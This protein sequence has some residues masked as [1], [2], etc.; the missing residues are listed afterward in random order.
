MRLHVFN[1][2]HDLALAADLRNFTPPHAARDL[3]SDLSFLPAIWAEEG[4]MV[5]VA[6][7]VFAQRAYGRLK[8]RLTLMGIK[9]G[10]K[11][12]FVE[13]DMLSSIIVDRIIPWGW[14]KAL[15]TSFLRMGVMEETLPKDEEIEKLRNLSERAASPKLRGKLLSLKGTVGKAFKCDD[16]GKIT[17]L[18]A[19]YG[20]LVAKAPWSG[21]GRGIRFLGK[22]ISSQEWKWM[23][24]IIRRQGSI[25]IEPQYDKV[26]DL[27]MEFMANKDGK[28]SYLGLSLF[29]T[30][31]GAYSGSLLATENE[32]RSIVERY[33]NGDL[34]DE[35]TEIICRE[36]WDY[37]GP[38]GVDMMIVRGNDG[39]GFL[40]HPCVEINMRRTM[41]HVALNISPKEEGRPYL[42]NI[43]YGSPCRIRI[44]KTNL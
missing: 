24:N 33:I 32:K 1:P 30:N 20:N 27:G 35:I 17:K 2:E 28:A 14:D 10:K 39:E 9:S 42:M 15:K 26:R 16:T 5:L 31:K 37:D 44:L 4:D 41:G 29:S 34:I 43:E 11:V 8:A 38:F 3:R 18:S 23:D 36:K 6:D 40:L 22:E 25:M 12:E 7:K 19:K 13:K 21:S